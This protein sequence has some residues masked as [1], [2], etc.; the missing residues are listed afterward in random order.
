MLV[1]PPGGKTE[2]QAGETIGP[3]GQSAPVTVGPRDLLSAPWALLL[4][5]DQ[6]S[7][8]KRLEVQAE[9]RHKYHLWSHSHILRSY[10]VL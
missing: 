9:M 4:V 1:P 10:S 7:Q 6:S 2:V 3:R 5:L 8:V